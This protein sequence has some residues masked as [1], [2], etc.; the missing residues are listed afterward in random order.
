MCEIVGVMFVG[1]F[2]CVAIVGSGLCMSCVIDV[3][4]SFGVKVWE[5]VGMC[6]CMCVSIVGS[7][8]CMAR[9]LVG[10]AGLMWVMVLVK[11][12]GW[13]T[14]SDSDFIYFHLFFAV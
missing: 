14:G 2:V 3:G 12:F 5:V 11:W 6:G 8:V 7:G 10:I 4:Y 1:L 13:L 9:V